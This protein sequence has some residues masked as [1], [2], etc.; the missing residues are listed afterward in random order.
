[1]RSLLPCRS[2]VSRTYTAAFALNVWL[3]LTR[4]RLVDGDPSGC[5]SEGGVAAEDL[6]EAG[7]FEGASGAFLQLRAQRQVHPAAGRRVQRPGAPRQRQ[8]GAPAQQRLTTVLLPLRRHQ[9]F[10]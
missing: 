5:W 8:R 2:A 3:T 6:A 7:A 10:T 1:M 4:W 9:F